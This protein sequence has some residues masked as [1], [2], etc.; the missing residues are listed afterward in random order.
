MLEIDVIGFRPQEM[1]SVWEV[2][3]VR[4]PT[5]KLIRDPR[6]CS[7]PFSEAYDDHIG[8]LTVQDAKS[9]NSKSSQVSESNRQLGKILAEESL[10][11]SF[12]MVLLWEWEVS[13]LGFMCLGGTFRSVSDW[14]P[15]AVQKLHF[16]SLRKLFPSQTD[17][18]YRE[19]KTWLS[20]LSRRLTPQKRLSDD[21]FSDFPKSTKAI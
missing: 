2:E 8:L 9:I 17:E 3:S 4:W 15:A 18:F 14:A 20:E 21:D 1:I 6:F 12:V 13:D 11:K 10:S 19:V 5:E 16:H 7:L